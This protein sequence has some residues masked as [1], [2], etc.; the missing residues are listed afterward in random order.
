MALDEADRSRWLAGLQ[1]Y[2]KEVE[3]RLDLPRLK[4]IVEPVNRMLSKKR[5]TI[6]RKI[7]FQAIYK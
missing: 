1:Y 5:G 6:P 4:S 7:S 3:S 2:R